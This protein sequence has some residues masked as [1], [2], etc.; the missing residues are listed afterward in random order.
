MQKLLFAP[1]HTIVFAIANVLF[2]FWLSAQSLWLDRS[3]DKAFSLEVLMPNFKNDG[4]G[5]ITIS[6]SGLVVFS[7]LRLPLP[8][9]VHFVG[10]LAFARGSSTTS[11]ANFY[12]SQSEIAFGNPYL[13]IEIRARNAP[14]FAELGVRVPLASEDNALSMAAGAITD[15]DRLEAFAPKYFT[16]NG[17]MNFRRVGSSGF[18]IRLRAGSSLAINTDKQDFER[19]A[20]CFIN[21]GAQLGYESRQLNIGTSFTGRA[22]ISLDEGNFNE[23]TIHQLGFATS[24]R[25]GQFWPGLQV[26][27]PLDDE[28]KTYIDAVFGVQLGIEL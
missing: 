17:M 21:Y 7:S 27:L 10:E 26:R 8:E 19:H 24:M 12:S 5:T 15:F 9:Q 16:L 2:P 18:M 23:R 22:N 1:R 3:H 20:D 14:I 28:L 11:E 25:L 4:A 13:G 6:N